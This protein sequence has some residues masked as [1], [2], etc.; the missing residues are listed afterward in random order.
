MAIQIAFLLFG[1]VMILA[2]AEFFTNGI[3]AFGRKFSFSQA[4]VGSIFAAVGTALPETILPMVAIF[5]YGG[6]SSKEIG[7]G[8]ILGA[9]FMLSTLAF[10]LV[11][12]TA[13]VAAFNKKRPFEL[14]VEIRS[15]RRDMSFFIVM[16]SSAV[17][18]PML[19]GTTVQVPLAIALVLG[20]VFYTWLTFRGESAGIE[21]AGEMYFLKIARRL[22]ISISEESPPLFAI[23]L[24]VGIS[25]GVMVK[26][27][28]TFV[29]SLEQISV[30][31]GMDPLLFALLLAPVATELPEKFNS[32]TWT[33]KGRDTLAIGNITGAM[34]FQSTF[35]VSVGLVFTEWRLTGM[36]LFSAVIAIVS[37]AILFVAILVQKRISPL[38]LL[39]SGCLYLTYALVLILR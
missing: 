21:H 26:G 12:L 11:G 32:M 29:S 2:A 3:E 22:G 36:A 16:Y 17:F 18:L 13:S 23:L 9:P 34:V 10:F 38:T 37:S 7:V 31:F 24:Q 27:A 35:P 8:A 1:L 6:H 25:L 5:L 30:R 20:Y 19:I 14:R 39:F 15:V 28:H 33:W 4:V